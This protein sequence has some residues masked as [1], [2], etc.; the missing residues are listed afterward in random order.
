[1]LMELEYNTGDSPA[2]TIFSGKAALCGR[3]ATW[4]ADVRR[5]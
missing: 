4:G 5:T 3:D 2:F 1:M